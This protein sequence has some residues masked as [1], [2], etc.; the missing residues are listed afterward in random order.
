LGRRTFISKL[1]HIQ[2]GNLNPLLRQQMHHNLP[3]PVAPARHNHN[4]LAPHVRVALEVVRHGIV[5][6]P[7]H[8]L[9]QAKH[10]QR[11]EVLPC[12]RVAGG[13]APAF[14]RVFARE[15]QREREK[16]VEGR[17]FHEARE[18]V[19]GEAWGRVSLLSTGVHRGA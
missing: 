4:F 2:H 14:E 9:Q 16:R 15:Q 6:P 18:R 13:C 1:L 5:K 11:L 17:V 12:R 8:L 7:A 19:A 3:N 10:H